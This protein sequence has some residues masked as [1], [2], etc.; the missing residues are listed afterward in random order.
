MQSDSKQPDKVNIAPAVGTVEQSSISI[1]AG[2][3]SE[4]PTKSLIE[5]V[6]SDPKTKPK[7]ALIATPKVATSTNSVATELI[8][9]SY[10][11]SLKSLPA[12]DHGDIE[13][14][15]VDKADE[16]VGKTQYDPYYEEE[17]QHAL[18]RAYLKTRFNL[19]VN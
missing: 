8:S 14:V 6:K 1:E 3:N 9:D 7:T 15:W 4:Q 10:E 16:I 13:K 18:S 19:D 11:L 2:N 17:A 5:S 12:K